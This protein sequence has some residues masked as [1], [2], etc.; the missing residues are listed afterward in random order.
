MD[1][2]RRVWKKTEWGR[3]NLG[4]MLE[5]LRLDT[6]KLFHDFS[7]ADFGKLATKM[8][9]KSIYIMCTLIIRHVFTKNIILKI[10]NIS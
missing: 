1:G 4:K 6:K 5:N 2:K 8:K 9:T 3:E 7:K 10:K